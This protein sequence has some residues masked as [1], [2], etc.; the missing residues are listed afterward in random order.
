M[1]DRRDTVD[2]DPLVNDGVVF[3]DVVV[4]DRGVVVNLSNLRR[5]QAVMGEIMLL[6]IMQSNE[7]IMFGPEAEIESNANAD[8]IKPP[9]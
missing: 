6:E 7:G 9:S 4:D 2:F 5:W 3:D 8:A 1:C